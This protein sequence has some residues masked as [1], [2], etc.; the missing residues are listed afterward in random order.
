MLCLVFVCYTVKGRRMREIVEGEV[1]IRN[2]YLRQFA[3]LLR[4]ERGI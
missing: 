2:L 1:C 4:V 3:V